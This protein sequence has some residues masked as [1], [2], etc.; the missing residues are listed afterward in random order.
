MYV[1]LCTSLR[2]AMYCMRVEMVHRTRMRTRMVPPA[3][4]RVAQLAVRWQLRLRNERL[5]KG[6]WQ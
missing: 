2:V 1:A 3:Q 4:Y 6:R 5:D